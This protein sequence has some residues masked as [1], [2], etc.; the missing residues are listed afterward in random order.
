LPVK[1]FDDLHAFI[2]QDYS[3]NNCNTY[4]INGDVKI[5]IDPGHLQ[6]FGHVMKNLEFM[7]IPLSEIQLILVTHGHPD[8]LQAVQML[9]GKAMFAMNREEYL[10][11]TEFAGPYI[12]IPE[13]DFFVGNGDLTVG[14]HTFH[15][16]V[17]PGHSP[18]S[19]CIYWPERKAL[20]TGD[21]VFNQGIGRT[22]LPGGDGILL[23]KSIQ[24]IKKLDVEFLLTGHGDIVVGREAVE[25]NFQM[26]ENYW[27]NYL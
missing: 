18:G 15:V 22:D 13:P 24:K 20:F 26:I 7:S 9:E 5:L 4:F 14:N 11:I 2:W 12:H 6:L 21:L 17:T 23:K 3:Q 25:E 8:H 1:I 19:I 16:I 27:F 10:F